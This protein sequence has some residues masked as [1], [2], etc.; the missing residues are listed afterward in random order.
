MGERFPDLAMMAEVVSARTAFRGESP[1][2]FQMRGGRVPDSQ[3]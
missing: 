2:N 1:Q 3:L